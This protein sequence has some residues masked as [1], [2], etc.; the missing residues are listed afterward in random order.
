MFEFFKKWRKGDGPPQPA[1]PRNL[2]RTVT[3]RK[4][5]PSFLH[6]KEITVEDE[7][8]IRRLLFDHFRLLT[9]PAI[10]YWIVQHVHDLVAI[11]LILACLLPVKSLL[12]FC[13][14]FLVYLYVRARFE[15]EKHIRY[16]CPDLQAIFEAYRTT[17]GSNFWVAYFSKHEDPTSS[18]ESTLESPSSQT[19]PRTVSV[20]EDN[21]EREA[22][23]T[24]VSSDTQSTTPEGEGSA[25]R[26]DSISNTQR[27][28]DRKP[29]LSGRK[30]R[31]HYEHS[32]KLEDVISPT[33]CTENEILGCIGI[34]PY[35]TN[36]TVAQ[37]VRLVVSRKCRN[38]AVGSQLLNHLERFATGFGYS[39]IR[40]YTNNLNTSYLQFLKQNGFV[41][42]QIVRRGL[43]RGDLII[44]NKV[45]SQPTDQIVTELSTL[46]RVDASF[47]PE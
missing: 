38:M 21:T 23:V 3:L 29:P 45:L 47:I 14:C 6:I 13:I 46:R 5:N 10:V 18:I 32:M 42:Q 39:E 20:S 25:A 30:S 31:I 26:Q 11:I 34:T 36:S 2:R 35:R 40:V 1:V 17:K 4:V 7:D 22:P 9:F 28:E 24:D 19:Q 16:C 43:M 44:W 41:I 12:Y 27:D 8:D 33:Q 15:I 37:M